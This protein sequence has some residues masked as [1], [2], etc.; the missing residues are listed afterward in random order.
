MAERLR[1][2][3]SQHNARTVV[4][5]AGEVDL[6]TAPQLEECLRDLAHTDVTVDLSEVGFLDSSGIAALVRSS[7]VLR[8]R[9]HKLTTSGEIDTVRRVLEIVGVFEMFHDE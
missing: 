3:L 6:S 4:A 7:K 2:T 9:G 5:V 1:I 8:D